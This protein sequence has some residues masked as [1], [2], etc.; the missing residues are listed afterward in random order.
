M[1]QR[2]H[3]PVEEKGESSTRS[4]VRLMRHNITYVLDCSTPLSRESEY[5]ANDKMRACHNHATKFVSGAHIISLV[6]KTHLHV[7]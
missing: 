5:D 1:L 2:S 7:V 6:F 3:H 4:S